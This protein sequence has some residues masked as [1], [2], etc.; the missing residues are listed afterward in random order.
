MAV[1]ILRKS[2]TYTKP[3]IKEVPQPVK[4]RDTYSPFGWDISETK[5]YAG[6][7]LRM[8]FDQAHAL[9]SA[10]PDPNLIRAYGAFTY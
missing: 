8:A 4:Q 9:R 7:A 6:K 1:A 3:V 10:K 5:K 2:G